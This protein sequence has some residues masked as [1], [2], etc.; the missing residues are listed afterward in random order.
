[1]DLKPFGV[2]FDYLA[3]KEKI[4]E[5]QETFSKEK[6]KFEFKKKQFKREKISFRQLESKKKDDLDKIKTIKEEYLYEMNE[7][8][9][10]NLSFESRNM[11]KPYELLSM[12][13][14][15]NAYQNKFYKEIKG[16]VG[17]KS[18]D[19][20]TFLIQRLLEELDFYFRLVRV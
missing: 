18:D 1:M 13:V 2:I 11:E 14:K 15:N 7:W 6:K 4:A 17:R 19:H 10:I 9:T 16:Q 3:H 20:S 12:L 5:E 8:R